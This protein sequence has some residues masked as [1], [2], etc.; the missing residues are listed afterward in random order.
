MRRVRLRIVMVAIVLIGLAIWGQETRQR[1]GRYRSLASWHAQEEQRCKKT[2][3]QIVSCGT[4]MGID[5]DGRDIRQ[6][7]IVEWRERMDYHSKMREKYEYAG[8][9]PWKLVASDPPAPK[10]R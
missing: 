6:H 10:P 7:L 5:L 4:S 8:A 1:S 2:F 9:H 3:A